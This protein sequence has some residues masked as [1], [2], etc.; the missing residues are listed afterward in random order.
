MSTN[1]H[2]SKRSFNE[3]LKEALKTFI[4]LAILIFL[5]I[6]CFYALTIIFPSSGNSHVTMEPG[7]FLFGYIMAIPF[8]IGLS[9]YPFGKK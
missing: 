1:N 6:F 4:T 8:M 9:L 7:A 5:L 2:I 3:N